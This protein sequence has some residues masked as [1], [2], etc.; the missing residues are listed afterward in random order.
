MRNQPV[1]RL[2]APLI[3]G[4]L[5]VNVLTMP[6]AEY[7][8]DAQSVRME[9]ITV[10]NDGRWAV[11]DNVAT[12]FGPRGSYFFQNEKGDWY[13]KYGVLN[14][15]IYLPFL[16]LEKK[17]SGR[18]GFDTDHTLY[19]NLLN[20]AAAAA[21]ALYLG[22][23]A[24][25]Y[26]DSNLV[27]SIF[28][29]AS[30]YSTFWWNYLRAQTFETYLTLMALGL[31]YHLIRGRD[32]GRTAHRQLLIAG[33]YLGALCL[34][35]T[36][37]VALFPVIAMTLLCRE[38]S[39]L[40]RR[41]SWTRLIYFGLP[42]AFCVLILLTTNEY[43]FGSFFNT[44][45]T[46]WQDEPQLF[47]VNI[48]PALRGYLF[49]PQKS[50]F[51]YFPVLFFALPAWPTFFRKNRS[52]AVLALSLAVVVVILHAARLEWRGA[53]GYG[54][55][56]LLPVAP[57]LAIPF[58]Y[59]LNWLTALSN[60]TAKWVAVTAL[61]AVLGWSLIL[62]IALNSL[63]FYFWNDL[64]A[65]VEESDER[66]AADYL[67]SHHPGTIHLEFLC[68]ARGYRSNLVR[69]VID[70][71]A[72]ANFARMEGLKVETRFNYYWYSHPVEDRP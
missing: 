18:V 37:F 49:D 17:L 56:Y 16:W 31:Y 47:T 2:L 27:A 19:L 66:G 42:V 10:L 52:D 24:R 67:Y 70:R 13:P 64:V 32:D 57:I 55:R 72:P 71:L 34:C 21:T 43:K 61:T 23:L 53:A 6:A 14:T 63:P 15:L 58:V 11:P 45:Y 28:V 20:L 8:G 41:Q 44:G 3:F 51:L 59:S 36:V 69:Y 4:V 5:C 1:L 33:I 50:I 65:L 25:R 62:Q 9:A 68:Y 38:D 26:S 48:L 30:I 12:Q 40:S 35:K 22:L 46:Q 29:V 39:G 60:K 54:P 7:A